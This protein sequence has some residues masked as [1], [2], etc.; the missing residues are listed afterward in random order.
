M[1]KINKAFLGAAVL[2]MTSLTGCIKETFP[3][4]STA[5]DEQVAGSPAAI[6]AMASGMPAST[7]KVWD[8]DSHCYFGYPAEMIVRD[9]MTGD[10]FHNGETGY[11]HF[12]GWSRNQYM[13]DQYKRTQFHWNFY[14]GA[15]LGVNQLIGAVSAKPE[16][17]RTDEIKGYL[18]EAYAFRAMFYLDL[19]RMYEFLPC[20]IFPDG[21]NEQGVNVTNLTVPIVTDATTPAEA[22]NN[23][24]ATREQMAKFI[25]DDLNKA[26][27]NIIYQTSTEGGTQPTLACVYGLKARLYM[28][29]EDYDKAATYADKAI[30]ESGM[31]PL[32][33]SVALNPKTGYNTADQF[34]WSMQQTSSNDCVQTGIINWSSWMTNQTTFGYTGA[35]TTLWVVIDKA[36]YDEIA[37]SDWRK[38]QWIAPEGSVL[39]GQSVVTS[40]DATTGI[41]EYASVKFRP[42]NGDAEDYNVGAATAVPLMRV[43]EMH[44]IKAEAQ[45]HINREEEAL[46]TLSYIMK[47]RNPN[48]IC[49]KSG[50]DLIKEIVLQKRIELWG[51]GQSFYDIKR[52]NMSVTRG[53]TGTNNKD[54]QSLLNTEGRPAWMTFV[55]VRTESNNNHAL[56]GMNNPDPS[57]LYTP[58]TE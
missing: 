50:D 4:S 19:A 40:A 20:D 7:L 26:E 41:I 13:G 37:N 16:A 34:M 42:G 30:T 51:E 44:F 54:V 8:T 39:D 18:G 6:Q 57:G 52:L 2:C 25:E 11:S 36:L 38:K 22:A 55:M 17:D 45:A 46:Q 47:T 31:E 27:A 49:V 10:M 43:E 5:T 29:I 3:Q 28:W 53:Y 58:W 48:Y 15:L 23:P 35:A 56:E 32:T 12:I 33:E 14:Y 1:K 9:M 24:R 21:L